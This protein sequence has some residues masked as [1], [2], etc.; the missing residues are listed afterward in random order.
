MKRRRALVHAAVF[1]AFALGATSAHATIEEEFG[2][3]LED[4][5][6]GSTLP[7]E[8]G[9]PLPDSGSGGSTLP[10]EFGT[11]LPETLTAAQ[12]EEYL[13]TSLVQEQLSNG[14]LPELLVTE[15][16]PA[17]WVVL[18]PPP[19]QSLR[20]ASRAGVLLPITCFGPC[21]AQGSVELGRVASAIADRFSRFRVSAAR[22]RVTL[23]TA[24]KS[25]AD[26]GRKAFRA[27]LTPKAKRA[28]RS[29]GRPVKM[30]VR[31]T[32]RH[33]DGAVHRRSHEV[34]IKP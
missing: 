1:A 27:K 24:S 10:E 19:R 21:S 11:P 18:R 8:F 2:T 32:V 34:T 14:I 13:A 5:S 28:L 22:R 31:V 17:E 12:L 30:R 33:A 20:S 26:N 15:L 23:G 16:I 4:S 3:P 29:L 7:E 6:G 25:Y 9:T